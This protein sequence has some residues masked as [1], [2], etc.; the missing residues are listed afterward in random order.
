MEPSA[1]AGARSEVIHGRSRLGRILTYGAALCALPTLSGVQ[2]DIDEVRL[3]VNG[4]HTDSSGLELPILLS[5]QL[6]CFVGLPAERKLVACSA[7]PCNSWN[8]CRLT[9]SQLLSS[10]QSVNSGNPENGSAFAKYTL[11]FD[12]LT[13]L[14]PVPSLNES[15]P[16]RPSCKLSY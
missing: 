13:E 1:H 6:G 12:I 8:I 9:M 5:F 14:P 16:E 3:G 2:S 7:R 10:L 15:R 11:M 4:N